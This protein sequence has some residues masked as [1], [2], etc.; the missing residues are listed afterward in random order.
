M[1]IPKDIKIYFAITLSLILLTGCGKSSDD[2]KN[3]EAATGSQNTEKANPN[4]VQYY[5]TDPLGFTTVRTPHSPVDGVNIP[6][7]ARHHDRIHVNNIGALYEVFNDSNKYQYAEAEKLGIKPI[8]S[9]ADAYR[10]ERP[11]VHIKDCDAYGLDKLTHSMPY[12]VPEAA[13]L[14]EDIGYN[15]IDSLA[16]RGADGYKIKVTS[17]L[18]TPASV[19]KLRRV[20]K[21]ATDSSTHQFGTTFDISW[22]N[23][24][25]LDTTRTI[26]EGDL[27]NL[28]AEV[29]NDLRNQK[30]CMVKFERKSACFHITVTAPDKN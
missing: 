29:L 2:N 10:T 19:K 28:L 12:L 9:I 26:H 13:E 4:T 15:F 7:G 1:F 22:S 20:N 23:F 24:V 25:C 30:R 27:K 3:D 21:N 5:Y 16:R 17:L 6:T 18:R 14:L 11:L 8:H